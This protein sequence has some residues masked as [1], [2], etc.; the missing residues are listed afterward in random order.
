M[1]KH[2]KASRFISSALMA[3]ALAFTSAAYAQHGH[4]HEH[5]HC[6]WHKSSNVDAGKMAT[7]RLAK[8]ETALKITPSQEPAWRAFSSKMKERAEN[9]QTLHKTM[10]DTNGGSAPERMTQ[11][12]E[13]MKQRA[14]TMESM[15]GSLKDLY[16]VLTPEQRTVMDH[17]FSHHGARGHKFSDK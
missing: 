13:T 17:H 15:A 4:K 14:T 1:E 12:A 7:E 9:M 5:E 6:D 3:A 10:Q 2:M 16:A 11:Y 8:L